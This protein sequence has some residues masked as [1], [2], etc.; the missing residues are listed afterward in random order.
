MLKATSCK[1]K[2]HFSSNHPVRG[3]KPAHRRC[4][5]KS[6]LAGAQPGTL[7]FRCTVARDPT[8]GYHCGGGGAGLGAPAPGPAAPRLDSP[9]RREL[10]PER[11]GRAQEAAS[12]QR[13]RPIPSARTGT[14][15][16]RGSGDWGRRFP[17]PA[18]A[19]ARQGFPSR[20]S[21]FPSRPVKDMCYTTRQVRGAGIQGHPSLPPGAAACISRGPGRAEGRPAGTRG[22]QR[23]A[24]RLR[25]GRWRGLRRAAAPGSAPGARRIPRRPPPGVFIQT[26]VAG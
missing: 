19:P 1:Q 23:G 3:S 21:A 6:H 16:H 18:K 26:L 20:P 14:G 24:H 15:V 22:R 2:T 4:H 9:R 8:A 25:M 5:S 12:A 10:G 13:P 11:K 17:D 7:G